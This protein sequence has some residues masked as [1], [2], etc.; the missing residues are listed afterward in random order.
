MPA[1]ESR[2]Y[3]VNHSKPGLQGKAV[4]KEVEMRIARIHA[5]LEKMKLL[6][7]KNQSYQEEQ[8]VQATLRD[9]HQSVLSSS[10]SECILTCFSELKGI[11]DECN[12]KYGRK[13]KSSIFNAIKPLFQ[14]NGFLAQLERLEVNLSYAYQ[15]WIVRNS[16]V[17]SWLLVAYP[18][19]APQ[20][21]TAYS[22]R[23]SRHLTGRE[24]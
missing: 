17:V 10:Q 13:T 11:C 4:P 21:R 20:D 14:K 15:N 12:K 5:E 8:A 19:L 7:D 6:M 22:Y 3:R 2:R 16:L 1:G 24:D 18:I 9:L 23:V